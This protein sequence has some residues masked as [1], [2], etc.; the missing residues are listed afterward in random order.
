MVL[1]FLRRIDPGFQLLENEQIV[2]IH[3]TTV[4]HLALEIG[5]TLCDQRGCNM[6]CW[7]R[8]QLKSFKLRNVAARAITDIHDILREVRGRNSDDAPFCRP[9]R[10]KAVIGLA[11]DAGNKR[12]LKLDHHMPRHRHD[13]G[14]AVAGGGQQHDG[15]GSIS[16]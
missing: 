1:G 8:R 13:V 9:Q 5:E 14:T 10:R 6:F 11:D 15:P 2:L 4:G 7:Y 3:Q 12:W 16:W